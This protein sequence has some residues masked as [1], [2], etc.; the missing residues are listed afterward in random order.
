MKLEG[1]RETRQKIYIF[2]QRAHARF[3]LSTA[4]L[5]GNSIY[6]KK[7]DSVFVIHTTAMH[8]NT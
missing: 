4:D 3:L 6:V 8:V 7:F 5:I 1:K 2:I